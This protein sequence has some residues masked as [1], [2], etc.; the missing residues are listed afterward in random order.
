[1]RCFINIRRITACQQLAICSFLQWK[2]VSQGFKGANF[3]DVNLWGF[4]SPPCLKDHEQRLLNDL[5]FIDD[6]TQPLHADNRSM[7]LKNLHGLLGIITL[8]I[9]DL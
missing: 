8:H 4:K 9:K 3:G 6:V 1:M 7:I 2:N 5:E